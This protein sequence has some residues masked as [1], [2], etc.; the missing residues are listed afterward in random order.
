MAQFLLKTAQTQ[1]SSVL[2]Y[3][4]SQVNQH[5]PSTA[6]RTDQCCLPLPKCQMNFCLGR[7]H[8]QPH[9]SPSLRVVAV[10]F[11]L[12][13]PSY[14]Y[15]HSVVNSQIAQTSP[16]G[17]KNCHLNYGSSASVPKSTSS[18]FFFFSQ[19]LIF[20]CLHGENQ[21]PAPTDLESISQEWLSF[22]CEKRQINLYFCVLWSIVSPAAENT[23]Q[24][25]RS[26]PG[27]RGQRKNSLRSGMNDL[28]FAALCAYTFY[29]V[30]K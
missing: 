28:S 30:S 18:P 25:L 6:A 20:T 13:S 23:G 8:Q 24:S 26:D 12:C 29:I 17:K 7:W 10:L 4:H 21:K 16:K 22:C 3:P 1:T 5:I 2:H 9:K 27:K 15:Q 14:S 11:M 19:F